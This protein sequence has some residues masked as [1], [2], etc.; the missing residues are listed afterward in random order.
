MKTSVLTYKKDYM[1]I[2][3]FVGIFYYFYFI[4]F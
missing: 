4:F 2:L 1:D 3:M